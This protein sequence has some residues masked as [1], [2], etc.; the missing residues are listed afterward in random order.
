[1]SLP[2]PDASTLTAP[3][4]GASVVAL[5]VQPG[6]LDPA[7]LAQVVGGTDA[8]RLER[9]VVAC[10]VASDHLYGA[11]GRRWQGAGG[12]RVVV[13]AP[14]ARGGWAVGVDGHHLTGVAGHRSTSWCMPPRIPLPDYPITAITE[15]VTAAGLV[16]VDPALY[17]LD[18][19][20]GLVIV[21]PDGVPAWATN[22]WGCTEYRISYVFGMTPP[23][24]GREAARK[25]AGQL[26]LAGIP[27]ADGCELPE[28]VQTVSRQGITMGF[29]V[30]DFAFL[31]KG[32]TGIRDV[33]TWISSV[34][35]TG[36]QRRPSVWSPDTHGTVR[37]L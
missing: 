27:D 18:R 21:R 34:N 29:A 36:T 24:G 13:A 16:A 14:A 23:P 9:L 1:M 26:L 22:G 17:R 19:N 8:E 4:L 2:L 12:R 25:F 32:R 37:T 6:D 15:V 5:W 10:T 3:A 7:I 11:S 31:D 28:R 35:P 30:D 20:S 33:D